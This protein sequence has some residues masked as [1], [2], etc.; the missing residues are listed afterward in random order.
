M[1]RIAI[2]MDEVMADTMGRKIEWYERDYKVKLN[3]ADM[4]GKYL[5]QYVPREHRDV[6]INYSK[7]V[8]FF[9]DLAVV[10]ESQ[11]VIEALNEK[12]ELFIVTAAIPY[13][14]SYVHKYEWLKEHF[15]FIDERFIVFCGH[16]YMIEADYLIDDHAYNFEKFKGKGILYTCEH[17]MNETR[18]ERVD[19]WFDVEN[20]FL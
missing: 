12:Y 19:N 4:K 2:D 8:G 7:H 9:K 16:K 10:P 3:R 11:R 18:Y 6:V 13:P 14:N 1:K 20:M 15:P 17:N 5:S